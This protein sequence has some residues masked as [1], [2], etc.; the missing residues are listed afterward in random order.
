MRPMVPNHGPQKARPETLKPVI[1]HSYD[2]RSRLVEISVNIHMYGKYAPR[3]CLP[4]GRGPS[5][6]EKTAK[7]WWSSLEQVQKT[8][9]GEEHLR[10]ILGMSPLYA[11]EMTLRYTLSWT[12]K[13]D[14]LVLLD[15]FPCK[16]DKLSVTDFYSSEGLMYVYLFTMVNCGTQSNI[17]IKNFTLFKYLDRDICECVY[18][19]NQKATERC[20]FNV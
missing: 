17:I 18:I 19:S 14:A 16:A 2:R 13:M 5:L 8:K 11:E 6:E 12:S 7:V 1:P 10:V 20:F 9:R 4:V 15:S 3:T